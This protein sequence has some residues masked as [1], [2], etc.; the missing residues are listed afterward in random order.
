MK[1][2]KKISIEKM[3]KKISS[4]ILSRNLLAAINIG[5]IDKK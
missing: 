5:N 3:I 2:K 1:K 4:Q